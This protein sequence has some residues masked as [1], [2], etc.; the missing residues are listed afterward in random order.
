MADQ[1]ANPLRPTM[2][3]LGHMVAATLVLV[4]FMGLAFLV[5]KVAEVLAR[6]GM[7]AVFVLIAKGLEWLVYG[8]DAITFALYVATQC[9]AFWAYLLQDFRT[10]VRRYR[11][12]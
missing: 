12:S 6:S 1:P 5:G 4:I 9:L 2:M 10:A 7:D 11:S 8:A 3:F